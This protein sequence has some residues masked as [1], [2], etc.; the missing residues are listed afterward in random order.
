MSVSGYASSRP[1]DTA[2]FQLMFVCVQ[3]ANCAT[4][5]F[6]VWRPN[7]PRVQ[8]LMYAMG[9]GPLAGAMVVWQSPWVFSSSSHVIR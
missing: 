9:D 6:L 7:D 8:A 5:Y 3:W 2:A 4:V 1:Q